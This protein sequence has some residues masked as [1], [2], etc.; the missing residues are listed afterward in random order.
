MTNNEPV[1]YDSS[2]FTPWEEA[3]ISDDFMFSKVM[4]DKI[5]CRD[6]L[7]I[8]LPELNIQEVVDVQT[9]KTMKHYYQNKGV[10]LDAYVSD[11]EEKHYDIEMQVASNTNI[12]KRSRYYGSMMDA[13]EL[14]SGVD[15]GAL[16]DSY[17]I[18]ICTF[19]LFKKG[20]YIY[21]FKNYCVQAPD[22]CLDDGSTK[23]FL[24]TKGYVGE[25]NDNLK[26][27]L[28]Y[29]DGKDPGDDDL[30]NRFDKAV[31]EARKS[32]TWRGE[33][34]TYKEIERRGYLQGKNEG[35][36]EGKEEGLREAK[37]QDVDEIKNA[38]K[39]GLISEEAAKELISRISNK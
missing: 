2:I 18:F 16:N 34:M 14:L 12:R 9:Q 29:V 37:N 20:Q 24:N 33:Y 17:V 11:N 4:T 1:N 28:E 21:K 10:R 5:L 31:K 32:E 22:L 36:A 39:E 8:I 15:Y 27:F 26:K 19:D 38:L 3:T 30:L 35:K 7:R 23:I 25:I 6:L 13:N